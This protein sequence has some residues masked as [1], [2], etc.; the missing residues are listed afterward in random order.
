[1]DRGKIFVHIRPRSSGKTTEIVERFLNRSTRGFIL[2]YDRRS[3]QN[4]YAIMINRVNEQFDKLH[5]TI[6]SQEDLQE[7]M[8]MQMNFNEIIT[9]EFKNSSALY[10]HKPF[11][12]YSNEVRIHPRIYIDEYYNMPWEHVNYLR[13]LIS[14]G[15]NIHIYTSMY[16]YKYPDVMIA[17]YIN[18]NYH[19]NNERE[20]IKLAHEV[21]DRYNDGDR[22]LRS[23]IDNGLLQSLLTHPR[24]VYKEFVNRNTRRSYYIKQKYKFNI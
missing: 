20:F 7:V 23:Q 15:K 19:Y 3:L 12:S 4:L 5:M 13:E 24:T 17:R 10:D 18:K 14:Y 2:T 8:D 11:F 22:Q 9:D 6:H 1:M 16:N 21:S